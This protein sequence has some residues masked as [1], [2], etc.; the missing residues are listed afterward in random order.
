MELRTLPLRSFSA[1]RDRSNKPEQ[2]L[3]FFVDPN[4]KHNVAFIGYPVIE[5]EDADSFVLFVRGEWNE[6][7]FCTHPTP[8]ILQPLLTNYLEYEYGYWSTKHISACRP[9]F[10]PRLC[11]TRFSRTKGML[12]PDSERVFSDSLASQASAKC[13]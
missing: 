11:F 6:L 5:L 9:R 7:I 4:P 10:S 8:L 12:H 1:C 2:G 13:S 3:T